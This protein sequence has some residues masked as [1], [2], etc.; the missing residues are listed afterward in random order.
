M[1]LDSRRPYNV[2]ACTVVYDGWI[3]HGVGCVSKEFRGGRPKKIKLV[4][5]PPEIPI[6]NL[7]QHIELIVP[8][9][10]IQFTKEPPKSV[11]STAIESAMCPL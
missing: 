10:L 9:P 3:S 2:C 8:S 1:V 6:M 11:G 7:V 5:K 4:G